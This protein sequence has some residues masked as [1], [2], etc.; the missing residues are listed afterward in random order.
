[1]R[2]KFALSPWLL[3]AACANG[4]TPPNQL[5]APTTTA[6]DTT[7]VP[8]PPSAAPTGA[9]SSSPD[10]SS[11][12]DTDDGPFRLLFRDEF[13]TLDSSRWDLMTHSWGGNLAVFSKQSPMIADGQLFLRLLEAPAGTRVDGEDKSFLGAEVRSKDTL[14]YGRVR[15]RARFPRASGV[16]SSLVTIYTPWPADNWNELDIESL[17]KDPTEVQFNTMVYTG[18]ALE[19]PVDESVTPTQ[20]PHLEPLGFDS[21][22][23]YHEYTIEWTPEN[24]TFWVDGEQ[25]YEWT[26]HIDLM[27]LPQNV[28]LTIWAS[29]SESWAGPINAETVGATVAYDWVELWEYTGAPPATPASGSETSAPS[30]STS[31]APEDGSATSEPP[32][33]PS[34]VSPEP[35]S[36]TTSSDAPTGMNGTSG[37]EAQFQLLFRDDFESFDAG[38]WQLMTHSWDSNVALFSADSVAVANGEMTLTLLDAP[39]GTTDDTGAAKQFL[40]AEVRSTATVEYG[41]VRA[42]A[43]FSDRSAVVSALVTIYTPWPADDWNELDIEHL[44]ATPDHVQFNTMVYLGD[45][46]G[47]V[48]TSVTPTQFPELVDLGFDASADFHEYQIEWT[49]SYAEFSVDGEVKH[50][51]TDHVARLGLPQNVLLTIWASSSPDWAGAIEPTTVGAKVT[52]DW[53]E[54]YEY[55]AE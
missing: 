12:A 38:T 8:T 50:R 26:K 9:A 13:D 15:A 27:T 44:G 1:M 4:T 22:L 28:L 23:E 45:S 17:G 48:S 43:R 21:S 52:Y 31:L 29:N 16:V 18:P 35:S 51:W 2:S 53:V 47:P 3:V 32:E 42:R 14:T 40:G 19:P 7:A 11:G 34:I 10:P 5:P 37:D 49:P 24:A 20:D 6:P 25:R 30:A 46:V 54:V 55:H 36:E 39:D 33:S 41:R